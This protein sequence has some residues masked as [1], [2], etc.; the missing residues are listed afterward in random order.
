MELF[1]I[2]FINKIRPDTI[3]I[4]YR[5][6][7]EAHSSDTIFEGHQCFNRHYLDYTILKNGEVALRAITNIFS[8]L[9]EGLVLDKVSFEQSHDR[10]LLQVPTKEFFDNLDNYIINNNQ[11][12]RVIQKTNADKKLIDTKL[13]TE[14]RIG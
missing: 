3:E 7:L 9:P 1:R 2:R 5:A 14:L 6:V 8:A 12:N 4:R 10:N 11:L 13:I